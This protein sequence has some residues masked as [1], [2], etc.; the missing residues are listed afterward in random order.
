MKAVIGGI[1]HESSTL[2]VEIAGLTGLDAFARHRG[3]E[4][5]REFTGTNTCPGG[6]LDACDRQGVIAVPSCHA[7]AEPGSAVAAEAYAQLERELL[8]ALHAEAPYEVVLLDLH[9]AGVITPSASLE[10]LLAQRIRQLVGPNTTVAATMDLHANVPPELLQHVDV[11]VGLQEYP[12]TDM[13]VRAACAASIAIGHARG[14]HVAVARQIRLPLL[15][16]PSPTQSGPAA[17]LR[18]LARAM[19]EHNDVLACSVFHGFPYADTAQATASVITVTDG[20][21]DLAER[22]NHQIAAWLWDSRERFSPRTMQPEAAVQAGLES[23]SRPSVIGDGTDNPGA[24]ATGDSTYLLQTLIDSGAHACLAALHDPAAVEA[25]VAAGVGQNVDVLLGGRHGWASGPP[26]QALSR[27]RAITD[28]RVLQQCMRRGK[29]ADFGRSVRLELGPVEVIVSTNRVQVLDPEI[30]LLHGIMPERFALIVVKSC[31]HF[32][33]GFANVS[34]HLLVADAPGPT[35][36]DI[37]SIP[38]SGST[39]QLWPMNPAAQFALPAFDR[40]QR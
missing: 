34:E 3:D 7:R 11:L 38:R 23:G 15:L 5:L 36:R 19:E 8:N 35:T 10:L 27:V 33:A 9:G 30:L 22:C 32:K 14:E 39:A 4:L 28:G 17:E 26:I 37:A 21:A 16:P 13:A 18:D 24:G 40:T 25:A 12:H 1:V 31:H 6:Y 29:I 20:D 2:M